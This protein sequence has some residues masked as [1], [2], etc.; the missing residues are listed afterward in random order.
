M[1]ASPI[2]SVRGTTITR[3]LTFAQV[4]QAGRLAFHPRHHYLYL[5]GQLLRVVVRAPLAWD[6]SLHLRPSALRGSEQHIQDGWC[7]LDACDCE[8][9]RPATERCAEPN[10]CSSDASG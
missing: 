4:K 3:A 1:V 10:G 6:V 5:D 7:H 8:F 9:C 2:S